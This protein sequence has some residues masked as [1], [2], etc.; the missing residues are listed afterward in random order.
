MESYQPYHEIFRRSCDFRV[1]YEFLP[2]DNPTGYQ[3]LPSSGEAC[4]LMYQGARLD[5]QYRDNLKFP[6]QGFII[7]PEFEDPAG[8]LIL[9]K[10]IPIEPFGTARMW[11]I[12][13]DFIT[14]H[15]QE[16]SI[17][18]KG[19]MINGSSKVATCEVIELSNHLQN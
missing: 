11:I 7:W 12:N 8:F 17:G 5:F 15:K 6:G 13:R 14:I 10:W 9:G 3:Y 1:K 4:R 2:L 16:L 18:T 19:Y